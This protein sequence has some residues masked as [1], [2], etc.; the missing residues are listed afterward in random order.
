M[1]GQITGKFR[2]YWPISD[3][4]KVCVNP[5]IGYKSI[6]R[7]STGETFTTIGGGQP[8]PRPAGLLPPAMPSPG[9]AGAALQQITVGAQIQLRRAGGGW[10]KNVYQITEATATHIQDRFAGTDIPRAATTGGMT[11][12]S[13]YGNLWR[14]YM[15]EAGDLPL[16][17]LLVHNGGSNGTNTNWNDRDITRRVLNYRHHGQ[18][19][20]PAGKAWEH[21]VEHTAGGSNSVDNLVLADA[22]VNR[23]LGVWFRQKQTSASGFPNTGPLTVR[24]FLDAVNA[25]RAE[26]LRWK[27]RAYAILGVRL[28]PPRN[29]GRGPYR[30]L[31]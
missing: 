1:T 20:N 10:G 3:I 16:D 22:T 27:M 6:T 26:R 29:H 8:Q 15:P 2:V 11:L 31:E 28:Q 12:L 9:A 30:T 4:F 23:A 25:K 24:R 17:E 19:S 21:T 18:Q 14:L 5:N 7:L 13:E